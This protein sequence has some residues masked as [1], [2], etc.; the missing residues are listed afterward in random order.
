MG[1]SCWFIFLIGERAFPPTNGITY[2]SWICIDDFG[3]TSQ[4]DISDSAQQAHPIRLLTVFKGVQGTNEQL[5]C[6][7][8]HLDPIS[9]TLIV[10]SKERL[11]PNG[12][13]HHLGYS[14]FLSLLTQLRLFTWLSEG[15]KQRFK[16]GSM[17][18]S[19][20]SGEDV[21]SISFL[22][23]CKTPWLTNVWRHVALVFA[24]S[25]MAR[26]S[27]CSL[28]LDGIFVGTQKVVISAFV[29]V[30]FLY[31]DRTVL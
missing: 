1:I 23:G 21:H 11:L 31:S 8:I 18:A 27:L 10:S 26:T 7:S 25:T 2:C 24:R 30:R 16:T 5:I 17:D 28:Y 6:L 22:T 14:I 9:R 4:T 15:P 20:V 12:I 13:N 19:V 3:T 29:R